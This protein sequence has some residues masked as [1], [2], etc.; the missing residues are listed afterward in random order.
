MKKRTAFVTGIAGFAGSYLAEELLEHG[1]EVSGSLATKEKTSNI[2]GLKKHLRLIR[3]DILDQKQCRRVIKSFK[4]D[5]LF[6]LAA[7]ASVGKS[8]EMEQQTFRVNFE[9]T[10]NLLQAAEGHPK[11]KK[12]VFIGSCDAYGQFKPAGKTLDE[13][14]PFRPISPYGISKAAA[15]YVCMYY[16][17]RHKIPVVI[18]R[19]FNHSGPRQAEVFVI[20]S[21]ARQVALIEAGEQEP[22]VNVGDLTVKEI[23]PTCAI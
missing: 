6:H 11:M 16:H 3:L 13:S 17:R 14:Q 21:F 22:V 5:Y 2:D 4:P 8:F 10:V 15:E 12:F 19:A 20:P 7:I 23:F 18:A 1:F 9:G